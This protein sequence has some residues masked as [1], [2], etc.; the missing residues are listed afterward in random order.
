MW[1]FH[2]YPLFHACVN[3]SG[4]LQKPKLNEWKRYK[5]ENMCSTPLLQYIMFR[6]AFHFSP[7]LF[8]NPGKTDSTTGLWV[9]Q[10]QSSK[11]KPQTQQAKVPRSLSNQILLPLNDFLIR[12]HAFQKG[13][14]AVGSSRTSTTR[15]LCSSPFVSQEFSGGLTGQLCHCNRGNRCSGSKT[16]LP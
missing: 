7:L 14:R 6:E 2:V 10:T 9:Q 1:S 11:R 13:A 15:T 5:I 3:I 4:P 12:N 16:R 8:L